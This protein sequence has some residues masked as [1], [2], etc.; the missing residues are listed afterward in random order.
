MS[1]S[2]SPFGRLLGTGLMAIG[3]LGGVLWLWVVLRQQNVI[4]GGEGP[5]NFG[6]DDT[7]MSA[8]QRL[9]SFASWF[10]F[11]SG[12][13]VTAGLGMV[14]RVAGEWLIAENGGSLTRAAVGDAL[15]TGEEDLPWLAEDDDVGD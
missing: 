8:K 13:A 5:F 11:L 15:P 1:E 3:A 12:V 4:G 2:S 14:L 10:S 7:E 6:L 9:D